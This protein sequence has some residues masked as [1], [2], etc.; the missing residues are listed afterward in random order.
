MIDNPV[1]GGKKG[2]IKPDPVSM[3]FPLYSSKKC[4]SD[5]NGRRKVTGTSAVLFP[6]P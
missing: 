6:Y 4:V 5:Y 3:S 2:G 1:N